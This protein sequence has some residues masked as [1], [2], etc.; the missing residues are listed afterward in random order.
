MTANGY[1]SIY[2]L[3]RSICVCWHASPQ[4][5]VYDESPDNVQKLQYSN[6]A[7][8]L[9]DTIVRTYGIGWSVIVPQLAFCLPTRGIVEALANGAR[10]RAVSYRLDVGNGRVSRARD[11]GTAFEVVLGRVAD[12]SRGSARRSLGS[13]D[14]VHQHRLNTETAVALPDEARNANLKRPDSVESNLIELVG[15]GA[16]VKVNPER[17]RGVL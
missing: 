8:L 1:R 12:V 15:L 3:K 10:T 13:A 7:S 9:D 16:P 17:L 6:H 5:Q 14:H 11:G 4:Q 2:I